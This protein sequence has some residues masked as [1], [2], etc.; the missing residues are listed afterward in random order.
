MLVVPPVVVAVAHPWRVKPCTCA[1]GF[2]AY[3]SVGVM[4]DM[5]V[6]ATTSQNLHHLR[7]M[8]LVR[9]CQCVSG[10]LAVAVSTA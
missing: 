7:P 2:L 8:H 6:L 3:S 9:F 4:F 10:A 1:L 5:L